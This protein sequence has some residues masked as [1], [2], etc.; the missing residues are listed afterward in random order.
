M[1]ISI[2]S[3]LSLDLQPDIDS[4]ASFVKSNS[5]PYGKKLFKSLGR[6]SN[7]SST[8]V[9]ETH[10]VITI[11]QR[12]VD[13][14]EERGEELLSTRRQSSDS[15]FDEK[16]ELIG[17]NNESE[18]T[19]Q[20]FLPP[21]FEMEE[22][23]NVEPTGRGKEDESSAPD[24]RMAHS[25]EE[26]KISIVVENGMNRKQQTN[27]FSIPSLMQSFLI[28]IEE[29]NSDE[30]EVWLSCNV[31]FTGEATQISHDDE[32]TH[33]DFLFIA[34]PYNGPNRS[35]IE[36]RGIGEMKMESDEECLLTNRKLND[37][38]EK[39]HLGVESSVFKDHHCD[40]LSYV[41][42]GC[43]ECEYSSNG[44][45]SSS[46]YEND[47]D[48]KRCDMDT[49]AHYITA[50][51]LLGHS[52]IKKIS[53]VQDNDNQQSPPSPPY[54]MESKLLNRLPN[55]DEGMKHLLNTA[56][57]STDSVDNVQLPEI[58]HRPVPP[59]NTLSC[60]STSVTVTSSLILVVDQ[61][62]DS[63]N[64]SMK[65][66]ECDRASYVSS[67]ASGALRPLKWVGAKSL[68]ES[69][70]L[71][72]SSSAVT[73]DGDT[74]ISPASYSRQMNKNWLLKA[75]NNQDAMIC[76]AEV[77]HPRMQ[78]PRWAALIRQHPSYHRPRDWLCHNAYHH[79][80]AEFNDNNDLNIPS[81]PIE[82]GLTM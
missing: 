37:L 7:V 63:K 39:G 26:H 9:V 57:L 24:A 38:V 42:V 56:V 62:S 81:W 46:E 72:D 77:T 40:V 13:K 33:V 5:F 23:A 67:Y 80:S 66:I 18:T 51:S 29:Q 8:S 50:N 75:V 41:Q 59:S 14:T 64:H 44:S 68:L 48:N 15:P 20:A 65:E 79:S 2:R 35:K 6:F 1:S 76:N 70:L 27:E 54:N 19:M 25:F 45:S 82:K 17:T 69:R 30:F 71:T 22:S 21:C 53:S 55:E 28:S 16:D 58:G 61:E 36:I 10:S 74:T 52:G 34:D 47:E 43:V 31:I 4:P 73:N 11:S 12:D 3:S 32:S 78:D 60:M 49:S